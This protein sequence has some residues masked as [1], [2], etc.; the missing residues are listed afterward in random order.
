MAVSSSAPASTLELTIDQYESLLDKL[1]NERADR[2]NNCRELLFVRDR[3]VGLLRESASLQPTLVLRVSALDQKLRHSRK[4]LGLEKSEFESLR[5]LVNPPIR[6]WWWYP[7]PPNPAW[8]IA[9]L[10][11]LTISVS[12]LTDFT[13]RLLNSGPDEIG[14][15]SIAVQGLF[16]VGAT[17]TFTIAG[18]EGLESVL[19]RLGVAGRYGP[20]VKLWTTVGLFVIVFCAWKFLPSRLADYYSDVAFRQ[21]PSNPDAA[22]V[23]YA[24]AISLNPGNVRAHFNLGALYENAYEYDKAAAEYRRAI[25]IE[26]NHVRA[27]SNLS[28]LLLIGN[29][30]S[31][32]L[33][34]AD[35]ALKRQVNEVPEIRAALYRNRAFAE[36]QIGLYQQAEADA[37]QSVNA[38]STAADPYCVLA[39][40]YSKLG[41]AAEARNAWQDF[42]ARVNNH[43]VQPR[44][45]PD[46]IHLAAEASY[47]S[48]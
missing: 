47:A 16:A 10:F 26:P 14:L 46:C 38:Q 19:S 2:E 39:K 41:R 3:L 44:L 9:A 5:S 36:Y 29:D 24:R 7:P 32:A 23:N 25:V 18:R 33:R 42:F 1:F 48:H 34:V 40:I 12:I 13:R 4:L 27:Y 8:T 30:P 43:V 11:L 28:R 17:S 31:G 45:E 15:L 22:R 20:A 21:Q 37:K 6:N 35:D